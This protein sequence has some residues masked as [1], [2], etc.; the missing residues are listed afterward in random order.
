MHYY[1]YFYAS[2]SWDETGNRLLFTMK[3]APAAGGM[4]ALAYLFGGTTTNTYITTVGAE[5]SLYPAGVSAG[6]RLEAIVAPEDSI[7]T[8][9][10]RITV[11][12]TGETT[13]NVI[14]VDRTRREGV[15]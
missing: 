2:M 13:K 4:R 8:P 9:T 12:N 3:D 5:Y 15:Y 7:T 11:Y 10:Y 1:G 6:N 14:I